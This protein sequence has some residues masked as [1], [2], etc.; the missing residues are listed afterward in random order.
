MSRPIDSRTF[1][2]TAPGEYLSVSRWPQ[3]GAITIYRMPAQKHAT[4]FCDRGG[5]LTLSPALAKTLQHGLMAV[6][7]G[8]FDR[9]VTTE[10]LELEAQRERLSAERNVGPSVYSVRTPSIKP[11]LDML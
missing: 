6:L 7:S 3:D 4:C 2:L 5:T 8:S 9:A 10:Y 11:E 1:I